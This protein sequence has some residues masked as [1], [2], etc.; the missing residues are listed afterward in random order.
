MMWF[1]GIISGG[2]LGFGVAGGV[3]D[4]PTTYMVH[5]TIVLFAGLILT[6][7]GMVTQ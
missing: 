1:G 4:L 3:Y 5:A 7:V 6:V 2:A